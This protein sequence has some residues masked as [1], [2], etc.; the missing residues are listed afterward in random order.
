VDKYIK[1]KQ[2]AALKNYGR[3]KSRELGLTEAERA[4][5]DR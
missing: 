2:W 5:P 4:L 1:E 3:A